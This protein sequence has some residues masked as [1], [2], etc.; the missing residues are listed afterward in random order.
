MKQTLLIYLLFSSVVWAQGQWSVYNTENSNIGGNTILALAADSRHNLW[1][2][3]PEGLFRYKGRTWTDLSAT[4][5]KLEGQYVNCFAVDHAGVLWV[6]TDDY[7]P[8]SY[9]GTRWTEYEKETQ[10][11][12]MRLIHSIAVDVN[13]VKWI[14][15]TLNGLVRYDG[16]DWAKYTPDDSELASDFVL[17][18]AVDRANRKWIGTNAGLC[19]YN[20]RSW[21]LFTASNSPLPSN[22]VPAVVVDRDNVKW[23]GTDAGLCRFDGEHWTV[24]TI[25]NSPLPS[26]Q[27]NAIALDGKGRLWIATSKGGALFDRID[28]WASF[29]AANSPIPAAAALQSVTAD[30]DG[31]GWFGTDFYGLFALSGYEFAEVV[32]SDGQQASDTGETTAEA[33]QGTD[34]ETKAT[35]PQLPPLD[36]KVVPY[37]ELGYITL[38]YGGGE[39]ATIIFTDKEGNQVRTIEH[40]TSGKRIGIGKLP[41]GRYTLEVRT[42]HRQKTLKYNLK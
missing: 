22:I 37:L 17:C 24:Y 38:K 19:L 8:L 13:D 35:A 26:N 6:G 36:V 23:V 31:N 40:Y 34:D 21:S 1:V 7:G 41:K 27:I 20:G 25:G 11:Y 16:R 42:A 9:D 14:S 12:N 10:R 39:E 33:P 18:T 28:R 3:T 30:A 5:A 29:T 32:A 4:N 15:V 2:G